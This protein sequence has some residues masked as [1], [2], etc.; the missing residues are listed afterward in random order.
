MV[1]TRAQTGRGIPLKWLGYDVVDAGMGSPDPRPP[2]YCYCIVGNEGYSFF[3]P[4]SISI[5]PHWLV[6]GDSV[7]PR[8]MLSAIEGGVRVLVLF[9][10]PKDP[11]GPSSLWPPQYW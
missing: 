8:E 3:F 2:E 4:V 5:G 9:W 7:S 11:A 10:A 1:S 6:E